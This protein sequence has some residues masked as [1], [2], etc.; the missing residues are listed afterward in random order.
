M[1][2]FG[3]GF[4]KNSSFIIQLLF[5]VVIV[6]FG[7]TLGQLLFLGFTY[8]KSGFSTEEVNTVL[9]HL[10][11]NAN[12]MRA[13]LLFQTVFGFFVP[14]MYLA[15]LYS[16]DANTYLHTEQPVSGWA[17]FLTV[18]SMLFVIPLINAMVFW[19][20]EI[21]VP[22]FLQEFEQQIIAL[23]DKAAGM[24][25]SIL[26]TENYWH[27]IMNLIIIAVIT[28]VGEEFL[29]RGILQNVFSKIFKNHHVIIWVV[30]FIF[31]FVHFQFY[32]FFARA[33]LGIYFGY[34]LYYSKSIW[35]P[36]IAHFTNN[37]ISVIFYY[38]VREPE[39]QEKMDLLGT[40][41][42]YWVAIVSAVLF[43]IT[44]WILKRKLKVES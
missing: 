6:F 26:E 39:Y 31:S 21:P 24:F 42:T 17:I 1:I 34:L 10:S 7:L 41:Q 36:V 37:S 8:L 15:Y 32:G 19:T 12:L 44:V 25:K 4:L 33:F 35:V 20:K 23:E 43:V 2:V 30:G 18:L 40:G 29:F 5:C 27:F 28:A 16:D 9:D 14:S 38:S 13:S 11:K 3:R 22:E